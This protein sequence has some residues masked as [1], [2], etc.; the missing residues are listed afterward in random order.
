MGA[1]TGEFIEVVGAR[2]NNLEGIDL[3]LPLAEL[4]V[5]TGVSGSGKSSLPFD[6]IY[7]WKPPPH[8]DVLAQPPWFFRRI[9]R[10]NRYRQLHDA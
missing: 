7:T 9:A 1:K 5:V 8:S 4:I 10:N 2:Q 3:K 6:T